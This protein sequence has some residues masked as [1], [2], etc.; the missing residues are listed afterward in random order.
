MK[1]KTKTVVVEKALLQDML[2]LLVSL[3]LSESAMS[4]GQDKMIGPLIKR[5]K[6]LVA[7]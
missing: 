4:A 1:R 7:E 5:L 6:T 2:I 3:V